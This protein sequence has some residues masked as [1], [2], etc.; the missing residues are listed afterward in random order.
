M[1]VFYNFLLFGTLIKNCSKT[2]CQIKSLVA[3]DMTLI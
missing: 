2:Y 3:L 1:G